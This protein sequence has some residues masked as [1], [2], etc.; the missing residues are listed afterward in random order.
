MGDS[1]D[2]KRQKNWIQLPCDFTPWE[3]ALF[4]EI[5]RPWFYKSRE[6]IHRKFGPP[7]ALFD[8]ERGCA[9]AIEPEDGPR[10]LLSEDLPDVAHEESAQE[11]EG[12]HAQNGP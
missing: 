11:T 3:K 4:S 9:D 8:E 2:G 5:N 6:N 12:R 1:P 10:G 7:A